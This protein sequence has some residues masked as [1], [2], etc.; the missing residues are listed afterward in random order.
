MRQRTQDWLF[1][2]AATGFLAA[3]AATLRWDL[4]G[5]LMSAVAGSGLVDHKATWVLGAVGGL[6]WVLAVYGFRRSRR[7]RAVAGRDPAAGGRLEGRELWCRVLSENLPLGLVGYDGEG[8]IVH[9]NRRF[10]DMAGA[11]REALEGLRVGELI[12]GVAGIVPHVVGAIQIDRVLRT[13]VRDELVGVRLMISSIT[14][15]SA[16]IRGGL[17]LVSHLAEGQNDVAL[18]RPV[19]QR[20]PR[21]AMGTLLAGAAHEIRNPLFGISTTLDAFEARLETDHP[22]RGFLRA[23]RK[24]VNRMGNLM[25]ELLDYGKP[26]EL[27]PSMETLQSVVLEAI[28]HCHALTLQRDVKVK[29]ETT[30]D[31]PAI[32]M[33]RRHVV[34]V[35]KNLIANAVQH[36][37][38]RGDVRVFLEAT[39]DGRQR[40]TVRDQG[41]GFAEQALDRIFEPFYSK[42]QGGVGL[43]LSIVQRF[44]HELGGT[45]R[46]FNHFEGGAAV[47]VSF[48]ASVCN[49]MDLAAAE[50]TAS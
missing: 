35:F 47:E 25:T 43:G 2:A 39:D 17:M 10:R 32:P 21:S 1:I 6:G 8:R 19:R 37:P 7:Q 42:R 33:D 28:E 20:E 15:P 23:L 45:V 24:E 44:V 41:K 12:P 31:L 3:V 16:G 49:P 22:H 50:R 38:H 27:R 4:Y 40:C 29:V 13:G 48:P 46:A 30:R 9:T 18:P 36:S 14:D 26:L 5:R 11:S 34:Q